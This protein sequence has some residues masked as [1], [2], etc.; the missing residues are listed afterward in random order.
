MK[1]HIGLGRDQTQWDFRRVVARDNNV[2]CMTQRVNNMDAHKATGTDSVHSVLVSSVNSTKITVFQLADKVFEVRTTGC[3]TARVKEQ[4]TN[5][6][7][8]VIKQCLLEHQRINPS[9]IDLVIHGKLGFDFAI[10]KVM[11]L[12]LEK[13]VSEQPM[14]DT[15]EGKSVKIFCSAHI[16]EAFAIVVKLADGLRT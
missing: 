11:I 4:R 10:R 15:S 1:L 5:L 8:G 9:H 12:I 14:L 3:G 16:A 13:Q 2:A 7:F 6:G